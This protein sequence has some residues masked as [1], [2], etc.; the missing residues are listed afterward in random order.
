MRGYNFLFEGFNFFGLSFYFPYIKDACNGIKY[1]FPA[2]AAASL[3]SLM[4]M[5]VFMLFSSF[6]AVLSSFWTV[7]IF[8]VPA[9]YALF[10]CSM[11]FE[12]VQLSLFP[13]CFVLHGRQV[14][15]V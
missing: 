11:S 8:S 9:V 5:S 13:F 4:C 7:V 6:C 1:G 14:F 15:L 2:F 12:V 10:S 3:A